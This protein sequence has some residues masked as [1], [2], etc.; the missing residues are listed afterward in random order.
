MPHLNTNYSQVPVRAEF[1][2]TRR[3]QDGS[4]ESFTEI[5]DYYDFIAGWTN[6]QE[7]IVSSFKD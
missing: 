2:G 4:M 3:K 7:M 5:V 6:Y 1:S